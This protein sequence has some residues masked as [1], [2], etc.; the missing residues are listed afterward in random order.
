MKWCDVI[1][2][3]GE[4][5]NI[6]IK[7]CFVRGDE[8]EISDLVEGTKSNRI[9]WTEQPT[10]FLFLPLFLPFSTGLQSLPSLPSTHS[11]SLSPPPPFLQP[12][13]WPSLL[14]TLPPNSLPPYYPL[15]PPPLTRSSSLPLTLP[16]PSLPSFLTLTLPLS[17]LPSLSPP[18]PPSPCYFVTEWRALIAIFLLE[19]KRSVGLSDIGSRSVHVLICHV[20]SLPC[21]AWVRAGR[22]AITKVHHGR[23]YAIAIS[24]TF[25]IYFFSPH[26]FNHFFPLEVLFVSFSVISWSLTLFSLIAAIVLWARPST[27][28]TSIHL[29]LSILSRLLFEFL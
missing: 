9:H 12:S 21:L 14:L 2:C 3:T 24:S 29:L 22:I 13:I 28:S 6:H 11:A 1:W 7:R 20:C 23:V 15:P 18:I 26:Y 8:E 27:F 19:S 25:F 17:F 4:G 16:P 5:D 10:L